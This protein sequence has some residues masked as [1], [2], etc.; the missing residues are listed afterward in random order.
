MQITLP[1][2][3]AGWT[4]TRLLPWCE[5]ESTKAT[6]QSDELR[7]PGRSLPC[8][9]SPKAS[10]AIRRRDPLS[11]N[12]GRGV[13]LTRGWNLILL[14]SPRAQRAA[15]PERLVRELPLLN[16]SDRAAMKRAVGRMADLHVSRGLGDVRRTR[17]LCAFPGFGELFEV[18]GIFRRDGTQTAGIHKRGKVPSWRKPV[19][20][21]RRSSRV[22][23]T[24]LAPWTSSSLLSPQSAA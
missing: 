4:S 23:I 5:C 3:L 14:A 16:R 12:P 22:P 7:L 9:Q 2:K 24:W 8:D 11:S 1:P 18:K 6:P 10:F 19:R 20:I 21:S 15:R 17:T 13:G